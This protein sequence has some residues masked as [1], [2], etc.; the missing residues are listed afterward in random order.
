MS[1][2]NDVLRCTGTTHA[3]CGSCQRNV[4]E[5][6]GLHWYMAP[7]INPVTGECSQRLPYPWPKFANTTAA[8]KGVRK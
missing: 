1:L 3:A 4:R 2:P 6:G 5:L 7:T 8:P